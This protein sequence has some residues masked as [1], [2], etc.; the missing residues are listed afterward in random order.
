[1]S[2]NKVKCEDLEKVTVTDDPKKIFQDGAKLSLQE[3]ERLLEF[4]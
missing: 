1:M 2:A 4:L 3:K